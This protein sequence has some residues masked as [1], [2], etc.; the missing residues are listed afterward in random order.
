MS[1][2]NWDDHPIVDSNKSAEFNWN[3]HPVVAPAKSDSNG[4]I[5]G[6]GQSAALGYLPELQAATY[7]AFEK[8]G[9]MFGGGQDA[10][11]QALQKIGAN[12]P[13]DDYAQR[14]AQMQAQDKALRGS[15]GYIGG[16]VVGSIFSP[17]LLAP[18][19]AAGRIGGA[20]AAALAPS[21][22]GLLNLGKSVGTGAAI[23]AIQNPEENQT[24]LGNAETGALFGGGLN[25]VGKGISKGLSGLANASE[26]LKNFAENSALRSAG[27]QKSQLNKLINRKSGGDISNEVGRFILDE[28]LAPPGASGQ[29]ILDNISKVKDNAAQEMD[30]IYSVIDKSG[31]AGQFKTENTIGKILDEAKTEASKKIGGAKAIEDLQNALT[32]LAP[33]PKTMSLDEMRRIT[34]DL[35]K[36]TNWFDTTASKPANDTRQAV[37]AKAYGA[38]RDVLNERADALS[39]NVRGNLG[40]ELRD[41]NRKWFLASTAE[42]LGQNKAAQEG[43]KFLSLTDTMAGIGGAAAGA[44]SGHPEAVA[45]AVPMALGAKALRTYGPG[46]QALGADA[47]SKIANLPDSAKEALLS[48][49]NR[50]DALS[51]YLTG[52]Q[53]ANIELRR[54]ALK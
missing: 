44:V 36:L 2:F 31:R 49:A 4:I 54:K 1:G 8:I 19:A 17:A 37:M 7:P 26:N 6:F 20:A 14:L 35:G 32:E 12:V 23:G 9:N 47:L 29:A 39:N 27:G 48:S 11:D 10:G 51:P 21:E 41:V 24:R 53:G 16:Q 25:L 38:A 13:K 5:Q 40:K 3:E 34:T 28:N 52:A 45:L 46:A 33:N 18:G 43:N 15:P 22:S 50:I 42:T 30:R